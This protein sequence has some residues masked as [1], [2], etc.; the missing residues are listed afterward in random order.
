MASKQ[1]STL[2]LAVMSLQRLRSLCLVLR[3]RDHTHAVDGG[4]VGRPGIAHEHTHART[5]THIHTHIHTYTHTH[6]HAFVPTYIHAGTPQ[7]HSS[8]TGSIF[9]THPIHTCPYHH[10]T[11]TQHTHTLMLVLLVILVLLGLDGELDLG[12]VHDQLLHQF[13]VL[14]ASGPDVL[15]HINRQEVLQMEMRCGCVP[16]SV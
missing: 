14:V 10:P 7:T 1:V 8:H 4:T 16:S 5:R 3:V 11:N 9:H 2:S 6:T 12:P 13:G 15:R